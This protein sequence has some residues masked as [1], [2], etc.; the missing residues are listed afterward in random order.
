M[1]TQSE[2]TITISSIPKSLLRELEKIAKEEHRN[3]SSC[4]VK[5]LQDAVRQ[6]RNE[7]RQKAA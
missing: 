2:Q 7:K 1:P 4:I 5:M 3:R 6:A